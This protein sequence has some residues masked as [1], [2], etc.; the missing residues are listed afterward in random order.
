MS[1]FNEAFEEA[2]GFNVDDRCIHRYNGAKGL[3]KDIWDHQ[4]KKIDQLKSGVQ[5]LI[6][7]YYLRIDPFNEDVN[8]ANNEFIADLKELLK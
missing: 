4:Q 5:K 1:E 8:V 7:D 3:A 2:Y 6:S